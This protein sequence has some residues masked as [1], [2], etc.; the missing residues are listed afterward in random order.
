MDD[1]KFYVGMRV[2]NRNFSGRYGTVV[3]VDLPFSGMIVVHVDGSIHPKA[4]FQTDWEPHAPPLHVILEATLEAF[5]K[6][7]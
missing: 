5:A 6:P 2:R 7:A 3:S 4:G 1:V